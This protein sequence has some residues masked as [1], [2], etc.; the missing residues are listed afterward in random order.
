M[1]KYLATLGLSANAG[2]EDIRK[3]YLRLSKMYHPD[4]HG[5][6]SDYE[7]KFKAINEAYHALRNRPK[8]KPVTLFQRGRRAYD[9]WSTPDYSREKE[10]D[11]SARDEEEPGSRWGAAGF[12]SSF[13]LLSVLMLPFWLAAPGREAH[14]VLASNQTLSPDDERVLTTQLSNEDHTTTYR[15]RQDMEAFRRLRRADPHLR[16]LDRETGYYMGQGE[17]VKFSWPFLEY[18]KRHHLR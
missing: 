5:G 18:L 11:R 14:T 10:D 12:F 6:S 3:A 9:R 8:T 1:Q 17:T 15:F 2:P 16:G 13:L 7:E 4:L